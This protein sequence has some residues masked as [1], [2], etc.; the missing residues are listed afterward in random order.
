MVG[1]SESTLPVMMRD[2]PPGEYAGNYVFLHFRFENFETMRKN[3]VIFAN[4]R[5]LE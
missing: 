2:L 3:M 4:S 1:K 5:A